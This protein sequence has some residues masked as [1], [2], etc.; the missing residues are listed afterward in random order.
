MISKDIVKNI[1]TSAI[2]GTSIFL[3]DVKVDTS[4]RILVELDKPEGITIDECVNISRMI[5][6]SFD[7]EVEDYELEV[8]SPGLTEP[9]KVI[10]QYRKNCGRMVDVVKKDGQKI[11]GLLQ[12]I[13]DEGIVLE[14]KTKIK[15]KGLKHPKVVMENVPL[16]FIDIKATRVK[17][18]F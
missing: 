5:E 16:K 9:F 3:V 14:V 2:E 7:R 10:G 8:S 17:I 11:N 1:I 4:N 12:S 18:S 13:D 6:C 15:E